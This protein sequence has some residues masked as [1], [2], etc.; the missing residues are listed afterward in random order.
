MT[1]LQQFNAEVKEAS[2]AIIR[3]NMPE[4]KMLDA[5]VCWD[6][7][8]IDWVPSWTYHKV[9]AGLGIKQFIASLGMQ[10][11]TKKEAH[12]LLVVGERPEWNKDEKGV[13]AKGVKNVWLKPLINGNN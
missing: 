7:S 2:R 9:A 10:K 6:L 1:R 12:I 5:E 11:C 13:W 3:Q 4:A 8:N